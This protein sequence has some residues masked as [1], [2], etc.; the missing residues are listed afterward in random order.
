MAV[1]AFDPA[2]FK[3]WYPQFAAMP[4]GQLEGFFATAQLILDNTDRSIVQDLTERKTLLYMLV[5]HL[6]T[7]SQRGDAVTGPVSSA[8]EG[9]VSTSFA[10]MNWGNGQW[11]GQSQCGATYWQATAK[12]RTGGKYFAFKGCG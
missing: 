11:Y 12:Y 2:D 10:P 3:A 6:A 7:L 5:C 8:S 4:D 1:V 9:S